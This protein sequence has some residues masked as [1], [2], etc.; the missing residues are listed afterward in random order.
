M[1]SKAYIRMHVKKRRHRYVYVTCGNEIFTF[2]DEE[3]YK[4]LVKLLLSDFHRVLA[5]VLAFI[6]LIAVMIFC[7]RIASEIYGIVFL[8][9]LFLMGLLG[10]PFDRKHRKL[11]ENSEKVTPVDFGRAKKIQTARALDEIK[12]M[13]TDDGM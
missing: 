6:V 5:M 8:A 11:I 3:I 10:R 2:T 13:G 7:S 9:I 12:E 1:V 4:E